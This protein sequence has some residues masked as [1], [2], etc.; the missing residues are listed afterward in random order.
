MDVVYVNKD[1]ENPELRYSLRSLANVTHDRVWLFGGAPSWINPE[2]VTHRPSR[3]KMSKYSSTRAHIR[4]AC[5]DEEVSDPFM[6]WNDDF[7]A[8]EFVGEVPLYH[9]RMLSESL[10]QYA[11]LKSPWAK[12]MR[13]TAQMIEKAGIEDPRCFSVHLP[14]VIQKAEMLMALGWAKDA[15]ADAVHLRTLCGNLMDRESVQH[16]DPKMLNRRD[17]FPDGPWLS[18]EDSVF[19]STIEPVVRYIFPLPSIY[20]EDQT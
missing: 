4:A 18:S 20:E 15:H 13:E 3:Q 11:Q 17:P 6:L 2:T 16:H 8:M 12:G 7:F 5:L 19:R 1:G 10:D 14:M 9:R